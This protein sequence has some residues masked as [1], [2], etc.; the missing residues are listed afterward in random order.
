MG[1]TI[2]RG[3]WR[4]TDAHFLPLLH[5]ALRHDV[6]AELGPLTTLNQVADRLAGDRDHVSACL[7]ALV[8]SGRSE[9]A[10]GF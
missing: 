4:V 7:T 1:D 2:H 9:V 8:L 3:Q 5:D 6:F 10:N